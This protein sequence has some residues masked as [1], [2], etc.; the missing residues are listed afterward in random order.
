MAAQRGNFIFLLEFLRLLLFVSTVY[1]FAYAPNF[2]TKIIE[3][4]TSIVPQRYI[5]PHPTSDCNGAIDAASD[6]SNNDAEMRIGDRSKPSF[7]KTRFP[8]E[9]NGYLHLGHAKAISFNFAVARSFGGVCHMRLDDTNPSKEDAEYVQSILEDVMWVQDGLYDGLEVPWYGKVRKTSDY[10]GFIYDCAV[11]LI[12]SGDAYVDSL[13]AE[14]M[15]EYRGSLTEPGRDS[16]YRNRSMDENLQ[17]FSDMKAGAYPDGALV[18]RA[19]IAMDSPN[20]NMRDPALYRIK[21]ESHQETGDEWCIYPM[22][23]FSHPIADAIEGITHSLCTLEFEDHRPFYDW[24]INK[25]CNVGLLHAQPQQIEFSRLNIKSTV[26]SKRKLIQLVQEKHVEGWDDPRLPTLSG[27]RRRG[28]PPASLRLFC[29]RVGISKADSNIDY[30]VLE[31]C[32]RETMDSSCP[33]AFAVLEPLLVTIT[34]LSDN[35]LESFEVD[36]HP[37]LPK[38]QRTIPFGRSLYIE[39]SDFFDLDGPEGENSSGVVPSG[40]KRLLPNDR[41]RL[42]YA[43]VIE[44]QNV[45]RDPVS[46]EPIELQCRYFPETRSGVTP[47]GMARVKGIIHWVDALTAVKCTVN[48]YDRLFSSEE[49]GK[50]SGDFLQDINPNSLSILDNVF[51]EPSVVTDVVT[52]LE[53]IKNQDKSKKAVIY[54]SSLSYQFERNGY[55]ALDK[56][57]TDRTIL[58]FNR[59]VTL[60]DTWDVEKSDRKDVA[61]RNRGIGSKMKGPS[62]EAQPGNDSIEGIRRVAIRAAKI[63]SVEPHPDAES[64]I[65]CQ[66]DC[67]DTPEKDYPETRT[68]VAGLAGKIPSDQLIGRKVLAITNLKPAKMRGIESTA[69]LLAA[70]NGREG[71]DEIVQLLEVPESVPVG[72]LVSFEGKE[73]PLPDI[74]LKSKGALKAWERAKANLRV[75][76]DGEATYTDET[77]SSH[78]ILT[79]DGPIRMSTLTNASIQ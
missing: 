39:R 31:D 19:K 78:R 60:R 27:L 12:K 53:Q 26:L 57:S 22:Y 40:F 50:E 29:E 21:H 11:A 54:P 47:E 13:S 41:V 61:Q 25:L 67:G 38:G 9:P 20:I 24:T 66:V 17:L 33:R 77:G 10:F 45:V 5:L 63:V 16:P 59:V 64:L 72:E 48:Q 30:S 14:E 76:Q 46:R 68:V 3:E 51:V 1:G 71:D 56:A 37:K 35:L 73:P 65:V 75:N 70:S 69:M 32:V 34:N 8:P 44:C 74:L 23:D 28:L 2:I 58:R 4:Q 15:R 7:V 62:D 42:R 6:H 79:S 52:L 55:F 18:L 36:R 43:Y 49:P